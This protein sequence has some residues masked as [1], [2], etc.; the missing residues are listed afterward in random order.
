LF[1][2]FIDVCYNQLPHNKNKRKLRVL[3]LR[4]Y[5]IKRRYW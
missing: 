1:P 2:D 3:F 5:T 4:I